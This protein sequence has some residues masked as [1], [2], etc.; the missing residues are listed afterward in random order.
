MFSIE[1]KYFL[2]A[3]KDLSLR[4]ASVNLNVNSSAVVRQIKK[5]EYNIDCKLFL[6]N[7]RGLILTNE[8]NLLFSFLSEQTNKID[9]FNKDFI[10]EKG[11]IKGKL[12]IGMMESVGSFFMSPAISKFI[13]DYPDMRFEVLAKKPEDIIDGLIENRIQIGITFSGILPRSVIR[14]FETNF[15]IGILTDNTH[16]LQFKNEVTLEDIQKYPLIF[17]T[18]AVAYLKQMKRELGMQSI[19]FMPHIT[20]NSL[21]FIKR[22]LIKSKDAVALSLSTGNLDSGL[23][24]AFIKDIKF[25][26]I[27]NPIMKKNKIG[28][29]VAK[30]KKFN[31]YENKFLD[32][33]IKEFKTLRS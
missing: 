21:N 13:N 6:R 9:N 14:L 12:N 33:L 26:E 19:S 3:A 7:S 32:I 16:P 30:S 1:Y 24:T 11:R 5:L 10:I 15:P 29:I 23:D 17:H 28:I 4:R 20:S 31:Q 25:K 18:G 8:G 22:F 2:Q 27:H